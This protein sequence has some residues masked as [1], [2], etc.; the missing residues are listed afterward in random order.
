VHPLIIRFFFTHNVIKTGTSFTGNKKHNNPNP[1][2]S[3]QLGCIKKR[4]LGEIMCDNTNILLVKDNVFVQSSPE[5]D[6]KKAFRLNLG[7]F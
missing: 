6:C 2:N 4:N 1:F 3:A 5:L 7:I